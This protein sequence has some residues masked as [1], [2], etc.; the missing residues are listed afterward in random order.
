M[1]NKFFPLK[2]HVLKDAQLQRLNK[3]IKKPST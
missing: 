3:K 1:K 2:K